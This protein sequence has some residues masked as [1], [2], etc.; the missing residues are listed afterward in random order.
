MFFIGSRQKVTC[1][2]EVGGLTP[3]TRPGTLCWNNLMANLG[4]EWLQAWPFFMGDH[5][6]Y[7]GGFMMVIYAIYI[8]TFM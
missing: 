3:E 2:W 8:Y 4:T 7:T 5:N 6:A 1:H